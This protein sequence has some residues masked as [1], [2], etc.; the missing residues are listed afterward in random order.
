MLI[1]DLGTQ[2]TGLDQIYH[3]YDRHEQKYEKKTVT[4]K[5]DLY[6]LIEYVKWITNETSILGLY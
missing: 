4:Y 5:R 2:I 6:D 1:N 3:S